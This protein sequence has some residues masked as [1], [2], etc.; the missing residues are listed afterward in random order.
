MTTIKPIHNT[1]PNIG[2]TDKL[3]DRKEIPEDY[4]CHCNLCRDNFLGEIFHTPT[5]QYYTQATR[6]RYYFADGDKTKYPKHIC[7]GH[8]EGY[9]YAVQ[10]FT[11]PGDTVFDPT[12]GTGSAIIEAIN[13]P[14]KSLQ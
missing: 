12:V 8:W 9:R 2:I 6:R 14:L 11:N 4:H 1:I 7:P 3:F 13:I 5:D 10:Q